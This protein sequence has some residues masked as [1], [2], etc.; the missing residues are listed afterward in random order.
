MKQWVWY[1]GLASI[2]SLSIMACSFG[3]SDTAG[4][5]FETE[6]SIAVNVTLADGSPAARTSR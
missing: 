3:S 4:S 6:N 5:S 1:I 2:A